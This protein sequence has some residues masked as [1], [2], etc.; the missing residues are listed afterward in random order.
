ML[1]DERLRGTVLAVDDDIDI[2]RMLNRYFAARL[3]TFNL[4]R[5]GCV[6]TVDQ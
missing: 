6:A 1:S 2:L 4:I 5:R 3:P